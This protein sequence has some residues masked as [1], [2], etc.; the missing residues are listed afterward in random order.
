MLLSSSVSAL[1]MCVAKGADTID[2]AVAQFYENPNKY[3]H[4]SAPSMSIPVNN[5][6][7]AKTQVDPPPLYA[8][9]ANT[10]SGSRRRPHTNAVIQAGNVRARDEVRY[11]LLQCGAE[12]TSSYLIARD[13]EQVAERPIYLPYLQ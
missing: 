1:L 11:T 7:E 5:S 4:S 3:S 2:E 9:P 6:K 10:M 12:L 13:A 8:P